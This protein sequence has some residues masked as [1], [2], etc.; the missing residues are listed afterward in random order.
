MALTPPD[1]VV[2]AAGATDSWEP[3]E[4]TNERGEHV[5]FAGDLVITRQRLGVG[6]AQ[7]ERMRWLADHAPVAPVEMVAS[8][9]DADWV[10]TR[11]LSGHPSHRID[12]HGDM[13]GVPA[14]LARALRA[15]HD[16]PVDPTD[17]PFA[18]G[19]QAIA[20]EVEA[21]IEAL[22]PSELPDPYSRYGAE[23]LVEIWQGGRPP[24]EDLVLSHGDP[25]LPNLIIDPAVV[26]WVDLGRLRLADRHLDLAIAHYSIH[27]NFGPDAVFAFFEAYEIDPDLVRLDH[28]LLANFLLP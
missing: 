13:Q 14:T 16:V 17:F 18:I 20:D 24:V 21:N 7:A 6:S 11:R 12:S 10:V 5:W 9:A 22:D 4:T 28:Y 3:V 1:D 2:A 19:W 8:D 15:L 27:R 23:R 26:G 25:S